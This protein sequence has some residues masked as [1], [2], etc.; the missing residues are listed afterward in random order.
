M[1]VRWLAM[2]QDCLTR[3]V[4]DKYS[5]DEDMGEFIGCIDCVIQIKDELERFCIG[6]ENE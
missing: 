3:V 2:V 5:E 4:V 6:N 1:Y